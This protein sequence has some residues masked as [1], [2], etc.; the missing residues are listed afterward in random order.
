MF[1]TSCLS[2][3]P[4]LKK[5]SLNWHLPPMRYR[6]TLDGSALRKYLI[7]MDAKLPTSL[8]S[9][10]NQAT[11]CPCGCRQAFSDELICQRGIYAQ[12]PRQSFGSDYVVRG[13]FGHL[14]L[15]KVLAPNDREKSWKV[16]NA[17]VPCR[18]WFQSFEFISFARDFVINCLSGWTLKLSSGYESLKGRGVS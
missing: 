8:H 5:C 6:F 11:A 10:G 9:A 1:V 13:S 4:G 2:S 3:E 15:K 14:Y 16:E 17:N 18:D 12:L 7:Q